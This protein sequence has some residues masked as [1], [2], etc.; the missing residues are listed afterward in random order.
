MPLVIKFS[1]VREHV[2]FNPWDRLTLVV[3]LFDFGDVFGRFFVLALIDELVA[4]HTGFDFR[5]SSVGR[6]RY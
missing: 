4:T 2:D 3:V 1:V 6:L 5:N